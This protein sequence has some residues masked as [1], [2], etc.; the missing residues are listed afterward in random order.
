MPRRGEN[1]HKRKDG[2]WEGR[3]KNGSNVYGKTQYSSVYGKTY[4][5]VRK[6][7]NSIL[8]QPDLQNQ[9]YKEHSFKEILFLWR[10]ANKINHKGATEAKYDYLIEKHIVPY[11]GDYKVSCINNYVL[12]EFMFNKMQSGRLDNKGGLSSSYVRSMMLI[13]SSALQFAAKEHICPSIPNNVSKPHVEKNEIKILNISEQKRLETEL[14]TNTN[15]TKLG[16]LISLRIGLRIGEICALRWSNI[17]FNQRVICIRSTISRVKNTDSD[18]DKS[19][20]LIVDKPKTESSIRDIPIPT[21]LMSI[22]DRRQY[23]AV[24]PYVISNKKSFVSPRTFEY[25]YHK[26]LESCGLSP[27]N[28]H[29]LRHT[30]ATRCIEAGVD[31]KTLSEILGHSNVSITLNTYVHSSIEHKRVQLEK[32]SSVFE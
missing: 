26:V 25:R 9:I 13:I 18:I 16:I 5:E 10:D 8:G 32:L 23:T 1:I 20:I 12:N 15:E 3:Y 30:F 31:V 17:D 14:L 2:R 4:S 28:Y 22:L 29:A 7:L 21:E 11:L 24:S 6:K 19:T 27:I